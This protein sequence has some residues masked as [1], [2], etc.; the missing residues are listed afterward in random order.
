MCLVE[1]VLC[2]QRGDGE[3]VVL[4]FLSLATQNTVVQPIV[5]SAPSC[6][7]SVDLVTVEN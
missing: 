1:V 7:G 2:E 6:L 5:C 4:F 3:K